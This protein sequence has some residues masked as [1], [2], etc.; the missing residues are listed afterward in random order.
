LITFSKDV[1]AVGA[2]IKQKINYT[3]IGKEITKGLSIF[4]VVI[5]KIGDGDLAFLETFRCFQIIPGTGRGKILC[6]SK[7]CAYVGQQVGLR[8]LMS[9]CAREIARTL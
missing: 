2:F 3:H 4:W 1:K 7:L 9:Q 6:G 8:A 5:F